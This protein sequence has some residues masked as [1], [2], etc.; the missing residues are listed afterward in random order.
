MPITRTSMIDDDGSGTTGTVLN[1]AWKSEL[2]DQID[3][4]P[5]WVTVP[6][7][8]VTLSAATGTFTC[9]AGNFLYQYAMLGKIGFVTVVV[10]PATTSAATGYVR[11]GWPA[12]FA[13]A[14]ANINLLGSYN[15]G[16][17]T[18]TTVSVSAAGG[19]TWQP[20]VATTGTIPATAALY[21]NASLMFVLP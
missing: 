14:V 19:L 1:A 15:A 17:L 13:A 3:A 11:I 21:L 18:A 16:T 10:G 5:A 8:G 4:N 2:Y 7:T 12:G 6:V 9:A 20:S